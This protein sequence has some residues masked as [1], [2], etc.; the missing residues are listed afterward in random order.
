MRLLDKYVLKELFYPFIF[1]VASFS[2]IFIASSMLFK[3]V[4]YITT[5]G[6]SGSSVARLFMYSMPEVINYTFPM[7]VLLATL[8]AFGKLSSSSEIVAMKSGGISYYRIVAPVVAL[9]FIVSMFSVVWAEKV[10]PP[11]KYEAKRILAEEIKGDAKPKTQEHVV[12]K[13]LSGNTQRI[14]YA[15][16][17]DEKTGIMNNV[18]IEE[19]NRNRLSRVQTAKT[20]TWENSQWVLQNGT[21]FTMDEK[22]GIKSRASF[23]RQVIP[24]NTTPREISWEQKEADEMTLGELRGYIKVLERQKQPTSYYWTEIFMRFAIPLASFVFA[25]L[26]APLGTQRQRSGSSIGLGISVIVIFVYYGIMAFTTGLGKGGVIPPFL[27]AMSSNIVCF[28]AGVVMLKK[29]DY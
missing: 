15:R 23:K 18:T 6:A 5:Y 1:G 20:A 29:A 28:I 14:T 11:S 25:M 13:T 19:F 21:V 8:M 4:K 7:S 27:G 12:I 24:L 3:I 9:G 10:V 26:G 17:F 16:S 22:N 2:S